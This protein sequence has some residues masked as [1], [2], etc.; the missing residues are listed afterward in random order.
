MFSGASARAKV[1][2]L[3]SSSF[4]SEIRSSSNW[5]VSGNLLEGI[6]MFFFRSIC[7]KGGRDDSDFARIIILFFA[8]CR[9]G[10]REIVEV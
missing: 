4:S 1:D 7:G 3:I 10:R 5:T 2:I 9:E 6:D 8:G